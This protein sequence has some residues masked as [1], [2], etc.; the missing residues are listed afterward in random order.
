MEKNYLSFHNPVTE[1]PNPRIYL[2]TFYERVGFEDYWN[3]WM[4]IYLPK[5]GDVTYFFHKIGQKEW[6][7]LEEHGC[8]LETLPFTPTEIKVTRVT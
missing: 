1:N 8:K 4:S 3:Y 6:A 2:P 7:Y 5:V